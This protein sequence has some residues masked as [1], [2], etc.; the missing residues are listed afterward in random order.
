MNPLPRVLL[1]SGRELEELLSP[2]TLIDE[3]ERA[4]IAFSEGR[5]VTPPRTVMWVEGN[6]WGV[7]QSYVPGYGVGVKVVNVIPANLE[8]G[9]PTIQAVVNLFDPATGSPLAVMDGGVLT[10]LRTG[11]ASAVSAKYMAP[12]ERGPVAVV[13]TGYQARYQLRF[14]SYVYRTDEVRVYDI[15][16]AAAESFKEYAESLGFRVVKCRSAAE[17][18]EGARVVI[19]ATTT[20]TPVIE[21]RYLSRPTHVISI[22]AHMRDARALDDDVISLAETIVVDSR[23][24]VMLETGD[25]RIPVERGIL[26]LDRVSELGEVASGRKRGRLTDE[27]ITVFK[28]VGLAIQDAAAAAVA[29]REALKRGVGRYVDL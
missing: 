22:G 5:T 15:R 21:G 8:R 19:E 27:G 23:E 29:Y 7:M 14:V 28:S 18:I 10:A 13:G 3:V 24:A 6:W 16:E 9:L 4:F 26:T 17:A 12:R 11:A 25:I 2:G 20:K 1:L